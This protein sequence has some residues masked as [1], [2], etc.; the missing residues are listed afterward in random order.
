MFKFIP[1]DEFYLMIISSV[2]CFIIE[3]ILEVIIDRSYFNMKRIQNL[4]MIQFIV[5]VAYVGVLFYL[6]FKDWEINWTWL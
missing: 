3:Y 5:L 4:S 1:K 6:I 2:L